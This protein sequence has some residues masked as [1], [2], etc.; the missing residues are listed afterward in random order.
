MKDIEVIKHRIEYIPMTI[1]SPFTANSTIYNIEGGTGTLRTVSLF[2]V[3]LPNKCVI[4]S[5]LHAPDTSMQPSVA[6]PI[7]LKPGVVYDAG[8]NTISN[9]VE[10]WFLNVKIY[11]ITNYSFN[12]IH[13]IDLSNLEV[14]PGTYYFFQ[15]TTYAAKVQRPQYLTTYVRVVL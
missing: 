13:N 1:I 2:R 9:A 14:E 10:D 5:I 8:T 6:T 4:G 3:I 12:R 11:D 7:F 15:T